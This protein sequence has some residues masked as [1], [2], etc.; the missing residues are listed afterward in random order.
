MM[1]PRL[2]KL[3]QSQLTVF[4]GLIEPLTEDRV[5]VG[6][7]GGFGFGDHVVLEKALDQLSRGLAR[8]PELHSQHRHGGWFG[9]GVVLAD[10]VF[11]D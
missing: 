11:S 1:A 2:A 3:L 6:K 9:L 8:G 10:G 7:L 5:V 4:P